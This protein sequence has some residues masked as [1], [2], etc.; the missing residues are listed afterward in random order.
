MPDITP[1]LTVQVQV[2]LAL[3]LALG[4]G[5]GAAV[6]LERERHRQPAGFRTHSLVALGAALFTIVGAYGFSDGDP[7]RVAAQ[8][9]AGIGFMGAGTILHYRGQI[10]GLTT[11]ASLW[12]VSAVGMASGAGLY[13]LAI[14]GA[15]LI[16]VV[17]WILDEIEEAARRREYLPP[18]R[19]DSSEVIR[20][21]GK[22]ADHE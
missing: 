16:L 5:L 3:R 1:D 19:A 8:I 7:T 9:V 17:L 14:L 21:D 4:L 12:A 20:D 15:A 13:V 10:R 2:E 22:A 18:P 6:G 11:A